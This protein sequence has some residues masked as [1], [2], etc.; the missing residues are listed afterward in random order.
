[1]RKESPGNQGRPRLPAPGPPS[2]APRLRAADFKT[3]LVPGHRGSLGAMSHLPP[4]A[5][6]HL[7]RCLDDIAEKYGEP[8]LHSGG[9]T[10]LSYVIYAIDTRLSMRD[11][12]KIREATLGALATR[13]GGNQLRCIAEEVVACLLPFY[14][15]PPSVSR[16]RWLIARLRAWIR[17]RF[18]I[19]P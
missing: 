15:P 16:Y 18:Q 10:L 5:P 8:M 3:T 4:E 14:P 11:R 12:Q 13:S 1:M 6:G 7:T 2:A 19:D 17:G 9:F